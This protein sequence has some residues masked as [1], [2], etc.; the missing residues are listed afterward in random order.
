M[1]GQDLRGKLRQHIA[2]N[3]CGQVPAHV[4]VEFTPDEVK[5]TR[6]ADWQKLVTSTAEAHGWL[7]CH[8]FPTRGRDGRWLTGTSGSPGFPDLWLVRDG[9]LLV[10]ELKA[11]KGRDRD[12]QAEWIHALDQVPGCTAAF[13][14]AADWPWI[15]ATLTAPRHYST[16]VHD[17]GMVTDTPPTEQDPPR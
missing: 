6:E 12:G 3:A 14:T 11:A 4:V 9:R 7:H 5:A 16:R 2:T 17:P 10:L 15:Q 8:V 1:R 13:A